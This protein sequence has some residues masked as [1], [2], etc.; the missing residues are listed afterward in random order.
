MPSHI[1]LEVGAVSFLKGLTPLSRELE[2]IRQSRPDSGPDW[3]H[4]QYESLLT[5]QVVRSSLGSGT[6]ICT[7]HPLDLEY[8]A[9]GSFFKGFGVSTCLPRVLGEGVC[10]VGAP[11]FCSGIPTLLEYNW[12]RHGN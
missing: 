3:S 11:H 12:V 8:K 4:F 1:W 7:G 5:F 2:H 9:V 6:G 10:T